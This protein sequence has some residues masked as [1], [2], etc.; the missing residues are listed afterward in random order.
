MTGV[1]VD[2]DNPAKQV[3]LGDYKFNVKLDAGWGKKTSPGMLSGSVI[4]SVG[5]DE[6]IIAGKSQVITFEPNTPGDYKAGIGWIQ[7]GRFSKG[8]WITEL[9]LNGD[10]NHQGRHLRLPAEQFEI[11]RVKLYRYR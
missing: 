11:Q 5:P 1:L 6:Y 8:Q 10:Q 3:E 9:W 4:I 2:F 7:R